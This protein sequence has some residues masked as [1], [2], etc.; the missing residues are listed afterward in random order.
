MMTMMEKELNKLMVTS[1]SKPEY[2]FL[3]NIIR[4][5]FFFSS[6]KNKKWDEWQRCTPI[7]WM[8]YMTTEEKDR[9]DNIEMY[10]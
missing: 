6:A 9:T 3:L 5:D 7:A 1:I 2:S 4:N 10:F 8:N